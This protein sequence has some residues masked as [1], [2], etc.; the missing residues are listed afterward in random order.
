LRK[1]A[2]ANEGKRNLPFRCRGDA[3]GRKRTGGKTGGDGGNRGENSLWGPSHVGEQK[4]KGKKNDGRKKGG[5]KYPK[6]GGAF[7]KKKNEN[8]KCLSQ[9]DGPKKGGKTGTTSQDHVCR[10]A[11]EGSRGPVLE[12]GGRGEGKKTFREKGGHGLTR[13]NAF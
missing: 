1:S 9:R 4:Q 8:K 7:R 10:Q 11:R 13:S 5:K 2:Q 12:R 3:G 6:R